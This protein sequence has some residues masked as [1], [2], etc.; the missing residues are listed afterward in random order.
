MGRKKSGKV[1]NDEFDENVAKEIYSNKD[2]VP[3]EPSELVCVSNVS[4]SVLFDIFVINIL[5]L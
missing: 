5:T 4:N 2:F 1:Y 3:P